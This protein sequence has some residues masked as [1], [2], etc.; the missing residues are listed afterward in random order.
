MELDGGVYGDLRV[1]EFNAWMLFN[2]KYGS[3]HEER[4]IDID[5]VYSPQADVGYM[6]FSMAL[7]ASYMFDLKAAIARQVVGPF[8]TF[9]TTQIMVD[10]ITETEGEITN[11]Q[12]PAQTIAKNIGKLGGEFRMEGISYR[13]FVNLFAGQD[14][15]SEQKFSAS[16]MTGDAEA[17]GIEGDEENKVF[18][19]G[20]I[21]GN[22][23]ISQKM[24][25]GA[26]VGVQMNGNMT[27]FTGN[28]SL[29]YKLPKRVK[30]MRPRPP[31][32]KFSNSKKANKLTRTSTSELAQYARD[33]SN[34]EPPY[35]VVNVEMKINSS[36]DEGSVEANKRTLMRANTVKDV[37]V[38]NK[39]PKKKIVI[40]K[41]SVSTKKR[42]AVRVDWGDP[43]PSVKG[44]GKKAKAAA[45]K[46]KAAA[47][48]KAAA[49]EKAVA[50]EKAAAKAK[51][52]AKEKAAVSAKVA[53]NE[54]AAASAKTVANEK[55]AAKEK[56]TA[57]AAAK[58]KAKVA[59]AK[60]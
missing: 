47:A 60:K 15:S 59:A 5:K 46:A 19:G 51:A 16:F 28:L 42:I 34:S 43:E 40:K 23:N 1:D 41:Q 55:A 17:F 33:L 20:Q 2:A 27:N 6:G 25:L 44:K 37:L 49:N 57:E 14:L 12:Y 21:G 32:L 45:A 38:K 22:I 18:Y 9:E 10:Q 58:A 29:Q 48:A 54:K 24:T 30:V 26:Q 31:E 8:I 56:A 11:L 13:L 39:I 52:A 7:N 50:N 36:K 53:A 3:G 35:K 4:S